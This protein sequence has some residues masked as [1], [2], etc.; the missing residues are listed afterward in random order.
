[1]ARLRLAAP[2][3]LL[4]LGALGA[5]AAAAQCAPELDGQSGASGARLNVVCTGTESDQQGDGTNEFID[6]SVTGSLTAVAGPAINLGP[7]GNQ[8]TVSGSVSSGGV[9]VSF[10]GPGNVTSNTL[11]LDASG[12]I[13]G[14]QNAVRI[15]SGG[16]ASANTL[17]LGGAII[18]S[19]FDTGTA[20][21]ISGGAGAV[22]NTITLG[23]TITTTNNAA[24]GI[25]SAAGAVSSNSI[26]IAG[27]TINSTN[28]GIRLTSGA[29]AVSGNTIVLNGSVSSN[30]GAG[31][32]LN[33]A[34][35]I[36]SNTLTVNQLLQTVGQQNGALRIVSTGGDIH[37]NTL[38]INANVYNNFF[39]GDVQ[40]ISPTAFRNNTITVADGIVYG[41]GDTLT[42]KIDAPSITQN[43]FSGSQQLELGATTVQTNQFSGGASARIT[44]TTITNN[45]FGA[46]NFVLTAPNI[47]NNRFLGARSASLTGTGN[48][49][50]NSFVTPQ[51][52]TARSFDLTGSNN[53][54]DNAGTISCPL[55]YVLGCLQDGTGIFFYSETPA[56]GFDSGSNNNQII[57][58]ATGLIEGIIGGSQDG[59]MPTGLTID[60]FGTIQN[61]KIR[62]G[63]QGR[64]NLYA[65]STFQRSSAAGFTQVTVGPN[66][67]AV[68]STDI[69]TTLALNGPGTGALALQYDDAGVQRQTFTLRNLLLNGG[70]WSLDGADSAFVSANLVGGALNLNGSLAAAVNVGAAARLT[71]A[72][73]TGALTV[74]GTVAPGVSIGA[75]AVNGAVTFQPGSTFEVDIGDCSGAAC[76]D[77]ISASGAATLNGG[78]VALHQTPGFSGVLTG[79]PILTANS[80]T[81]QFASVTGIQ[82]GLFSGYSLT[83]EPT[84]VLLSTTSQG[85]GGVAGTT[86]QVGVANALT[87]AGSSSGAYEA[88]LSIQTEDEARLA[89]DTLSGASQASAP[90]LMEVSHRLFSGFGMDR[91]D[92]SGNG[93]TGP[94]QYAQLNSNMMTDA[95]L[96]RESGFRPWVG[97]FGG[98]GRIG[99]EAGRAATD[100]DTSAL[101]LGIDHKDGRRTVGVALGFGNTEATS[102]RDRL[103]TESIGGEIYA[104]WSSNRIEAKGVAS[105]ASHDFESARTV[106]VGGAQD[107]AIAEYSG[108]TAGIGSEIGYRYAAGAADIMPFVAMDYLHSSRE[109]YTETQSALGYLQAPEMNDDFLRVGAGAEL[110]SN[111]GLFGGMVWPLF[112]LQYAQDVLDGPSPLTQAFAA[113]PASAFTLPA[114]RLDKERLIANAAL[115]VDLGSN[116]SLSIGY[117]GEYA[118]NDQ[119][120][121]ARGTLRFA[122]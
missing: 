63:D 52:V 64:L 106:I 54:V 36:A 62:L 103:D 95:A 28:A 97:A 98:G 59:S 66:R 108:W 82:A 9:A 1:M 61:S 4:G 46:G 14:L 79:V 68:L 83:Y 112:R 85:F 115:F 44:A 109:A 45:D 104:G 72:A 24:I 55:V 42:I 116:A 111:K 11:D 23:G 35:E 76:A 71:G 25:T 101:A 119:L 3:V 60:N 69:D 56:I 118:E 21:E 73:T 15:S 17:N 120:H 58:R 121:A 114:T 89:F 38:N 47:T 19:A 80:V 105:I 84:R 100:F 94:L 81:G 31:L 29:G 110:R 96:T 37:S 7:A 86:D 113:A 41:A 67:L 93:A 90:R 75:L 51:G 99:S 34:G 2:S 5:G 91:M 13:S 27:G 22:A 12:Q 30:F 32:W 65:G 122:F 48:I 53:V 43:D 77:L 117:E 57:N 8:V 39:V 74:S 20:V 49:T 102:G 26:S 33:A 16:S 50:G 40:V 10:L 18:G 78:T 92:G 6:L 87:A 88:L 107:Q 70:T